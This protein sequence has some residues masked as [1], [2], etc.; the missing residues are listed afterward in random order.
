MT[1]SN[2]DDRPRK[3]LGSRKLN[4]LSVIKGASKMMCRIL[5]KSEISVSLLVL[6]VWVMPV[7][8]S[9]LLQQY[10]PNMIALRAD[11][12]A[13]FQGTGS[14]AADATSDSKGATVDWRMTHLGTTSVSATQYPW[15]SS[16]GKDIADGQFDMSFEYGT[17]V[18]GSTVT[19]DTLTFSMDTTVSSMDGHNAVAN[20]AAARV[21]ADGLATFFTDS[22]AGTWGTVLGVMEMPGLREL[23]DYELLMNLQVK[24]SACSSCSTMLL[25]DLN[26]GDTA[27]TI[28]IT[29]GRFYEIS[30]QYIAE[31]P[32]GIDPHYT[33]HYSTRMVPEPC[34]GLILGG[35]GILALLR[36]SRR[37]GH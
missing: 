2:R 18:S 34:T 3:S 28:D 27:K 32:F 16:V 20:Q 17:P 14:T 31:A 13:A 1:K 25:A 9:S 26:A 37:P 6:V 23:E 21:V 5:P 35:S 30:F 36:R 24:E 15:I 29:D 10:A 12:I 19:A 7:Q 11:I 4:V 33:L 22:G 8:A